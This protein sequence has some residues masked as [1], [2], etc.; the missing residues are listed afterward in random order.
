[1]KHAGTSVDK[2]PSAKLF[3]CLLNF[4]HLTSYNIL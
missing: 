4:V 2:N 1:L 3:V